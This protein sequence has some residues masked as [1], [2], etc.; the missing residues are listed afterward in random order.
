MNINVEKIQDIL[1]KALCAEI[2][3][4]SREHN[5]LLI[6]NPNYFPDGDPYQIYLIELSVGIF[7]LTDGSY[8]YAS[9]L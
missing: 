5:L 9:Q 7:R 6:E 2:K 8:A 1:C 4:I 3:L